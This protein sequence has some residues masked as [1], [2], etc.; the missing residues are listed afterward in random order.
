[1][2]VI[3]VKHTWL[4]RKKRVYIPHDRSINLSHS[5]H[6]PGG[7]CVWRKWL[8]FGKRWLR[9]SFEYQLAVLKKR[10]NVFSCRKQ[11]HRMCFLRILFSQAAIFRKSWETFRLHEK[12]L[13]FLIE[14][15]LAANI[16]V[17]FKQLIDML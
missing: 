2:S 3:Q 15:T 12:P 11:E 1:M 10:V 14:N 7:F 17:N 5:S 13:T 8:R 9:I 6:W 4:W 16:Y